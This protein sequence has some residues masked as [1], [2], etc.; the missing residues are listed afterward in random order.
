MDEVR[1]LFNEGKKAFQMHQFDKAQRIFLQLIEKTPYFADVFNMLGVINHNS[2]QFNDAVKFFEQALKIN[3]KYTE[4]LLNLAVL[5]NDLGEYKKAKK[6]YSKVQAKSRE[7]KGSK[8]DPFIRAKLANKHA[9]VGDIYE[10]IGFYQEAIEEFKKAL[11]LAPNFHDIRC[12]MAIC[13]REQRKFTDSIK[14]FRKVIKANPKYH[15][16][17]IQL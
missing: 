17:Q 8:M 13:L 10:G 7:H 2:G 12:K 4:A 14:E 1:N 11:K 9:D 3:P 6:L 5:Y 16:A 15:Y